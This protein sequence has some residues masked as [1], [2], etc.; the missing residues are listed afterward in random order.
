ML[1]TGIVDNSGSDVGFSCSQLPERT[2]T[3]PKKCERKIP[4]VFFFF[5]AN[6]LIS[7]IWPGSRILLY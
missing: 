1:S 7:A 5:I 4:N 2:K 6:Y 3:N